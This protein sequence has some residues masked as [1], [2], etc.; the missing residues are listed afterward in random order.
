MVNLYIDIE[1]QP[2]S[3]IK[4]TLVF[5]AFLLKSLS[6]KMVDMCRHSH[7]VFLDTQFEG[8]AHYYSHT[9]TESNTPSLQSSLLQAGLIDSL[10]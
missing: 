1:Y 4:K 3:L 5:V 10:V 7:G 6:T 8:L 2:P 9:S